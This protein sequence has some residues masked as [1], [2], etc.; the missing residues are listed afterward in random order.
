MN[1]LHSLFTAIAFFTRIPVPEKWQGPKDLAKSTFFY[2][3]AGLLVGGI[4]LVVVLP[5]HFYVLRDDF[6]VKIILFILPL[7]LSGGLHLDGLADSSDALFYAGDKQRRLEIMRDTKLGVYGVTALVISLLLR[8]ACVGVILETNV[9]WP[10]L[11]MPFM[12]KLGILFLLG[13]GRSPEVEGSISGGIANRTSLW[14]ALFWSLLAAYAFYSNDDNTYAWAYFLPTVTIITFW[15]YKKIGSASG[16]L[17]G[18]T[19]EV[20]EVVF[21]IAVLHGNVTLN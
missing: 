19:N 4:T 2:P 20:W 14:P 13:C 6:L 10:V 3:I 11:F 16:D 15:A 1:I 9:F 7:L 5:L 12:G 21:L 18:F 17:C 8:W